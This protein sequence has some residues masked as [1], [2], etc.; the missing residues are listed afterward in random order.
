MLIV[1]ID[2]DPDGE[3]G[4][5]AIDQALARVGEQPAAS[6]HHPDDPY[7]AAA[8]AYEQAAHMTSG[9][10][11]VQRGEYVSVPMQPQ[12]LPGHLLPYTPDPTDN[13]ISPA[14]DPFAPYEA[15][16][17]V[18]DQVAAQQSPS[19]EEVAAWI[20][21]QQRDAIA[22]VARRHPG[23]SPALEPDTPDLPDLPATPAT[24]T[25]LTAPPAPAT[26]TVL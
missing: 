12:P 22:R 3:A 11:P 13:L 18:S 15:A 26:S 10:H 17:M 5:A 23:M 25:V 6:E 14:V 9:V 7:L 4:R 24:P 21:Q 8:R 2:T 19:P 1:I 20:E 16:R